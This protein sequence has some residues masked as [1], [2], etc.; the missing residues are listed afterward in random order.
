MAEHH[1]FFDGC[2]AI[3]IGYDRDAGLLSRRMPCARRTEPRSRSKN[4]LQLFQVG[5]PKSIYFDAVLA[6]RTLQAHLVVQRKVAGRCVRFRMQEHIG[7]D[8]YSQFLA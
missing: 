6:W 3:H 5:I 2:H 1:Y 7:G 4:G 8:Q